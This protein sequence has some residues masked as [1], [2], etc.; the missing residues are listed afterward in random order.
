MNQA[1]DLAF[2]ILQALGNGA[3]TL[4]YWLSHH[5]VAVDALSR[6]DRAL[7]HTLV[8][9]VLRWR[10][11]LDWFI[12]QLAQKPKKK[13][14][15]AVRNI[16]RLAIFQLLYLDRI[17]HSAAVN[18]AVNLTKTCGRSWAAAFVNGLLR[19]A[20]V[21]LVDLAGNVPNEDPVSALAISQSFPDWM[22]SRWL[23]RFGA[24][25]TELLCKAINSIPAIT[26]RTNTLRCT[27]SQ[28]LTAIADQATHL[29]PTPHAP[30]GISFR[31]P[32][33]AI[34]RWNTFTNGWFQVQ[35]EAAQLVSHLLAPQPGHHIWD[36]CAGLGT[37]TAHLA[38][39]VENQG[40]ILATDQH[41]SKLVQLNLEMER[42][43]I[44]VVR[45]RSLNLLNGEVPLN[46]P[47]FD[48]ILIDAPCSG[49]GV[50]Q[51]NPDGKWRNTLA[52]LKRYGHRQAQLLSTVA[53]LVKPNGILVYAVCSIE[54]EENE[55]V[56]KRFLAE[57]HEFTVQPPE[58]NYVSERASLTT[59]Q[60]Y[61]YTLPHR[62]QMDGFFAAALRRGV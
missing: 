13:I 20:S 41:E 18:T 38:Q 43:G 62:H 22:I 29:A 28:L 10:M 11:Q 46:L 23:R 17:P 47:Q 16:L 40:R 52:D 48:R 54:P 27:R 45:T 60:G 7:M 49:I 42:L 19:R 5:A 33:H 55:D 9:G 51:K 35:G 4:D 50:L 21:H 59:P 61:L 12:D 30:E 14:D 1:R 26:I 58:L 37:K 3:R 8:F 2:A 34:A 15:P 53:P 44:T 39:L 24:T 36:A 57:H 25:E 6:S 31:S 32:Q 56:V